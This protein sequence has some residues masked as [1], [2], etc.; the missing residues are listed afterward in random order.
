MAEDDARPAHGEAPAANS[1]A[2]A[3]EREAKSK[4]QKSIAEKGEHSY[5]FAHAGKKDDL[6]NAKIIEG[7]G[8]R[9]LAAL[10]GMKK[11]ESEAI[12]IDESVTTRWREDYAWGDEGSKVKVY[13]EFPEGALS[14]PEVKVEQKYTESGFEVVV[15]NLGG[16]GDPVGVTNGIHRLS[17]KIVPDKCSWRFNSSKTRLTVTLVKADP[18]EGAWSTLKK[19]NISQ[20]T[21]W[22]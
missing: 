14:H 21:G 17:G 16:S 2:Q 4:V 20:H 12:A 18:N 19:H 1:D 7:D 22:N 13:L 11:L 6:S 15:R 9:T 5:Y 3:A 8:S 10:D